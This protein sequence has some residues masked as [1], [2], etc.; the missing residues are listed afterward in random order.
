[1]KT[2]LTV[3]GFDPTSG[4]GITRDLDT[5]FSLGLQGVSTPTCFV[6]Q[7]PAGVRSV[8]PV[9]A[10][11]FSEMLT[12]FRRDVSI[13]GLKIGAL[14]ETEHGEELSRFLGYYPSL[15]VVADPVISAKNGTRLVTGE[16]LEYLIKVVLP[17]ATLVTP[18][19]EECNVMTGRECDNVEAMKAGA[20]A[21]HRMGM[22]AVVV[23]GGHLKGSLVD[24][25]FDGRD[26]AYWERRRIDREIHGTG[27]SFSSLMT[28]Y[29]VLGYSLKEAFRAAE[30]TM[31]AM[32]K[33]SYRI[34]SEGYYYMSQ[35]VMNS[36][37]TARWAVLQSMR[38]AAKKLVEL[39]PVELIPAVQ[40]NMGYA[41]TGAKGIEDVVAFPGRIGHHKGRLLFHGEPQFGASSHVARLILTYMRFQPHMRAAVDVRYDEEII[42]KAEKKGLQVAFFDRRVEPEKVKGQEGKSLDFLVDEALRTFGGAPDIIYDKGDL[43]KEP[44]IRLFGRDPLELIEKMELIGP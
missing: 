12:L 8:Q 14:C 29:L 22:K 18:N 42:E 11:H 10:A 6:V 19:T 35:G 24:V 43:G 9:P 30:G 39:N 21:L 7:S 2:I 36:D 17:L 34:G 25:L 38:E 27:C 37:S 28:A 20:M 32:L 4:A 44:I 16:A 26:F 1:M 23:K 41:V 3:A 15:P 33:H 13:D 5:F 31:E 40:M